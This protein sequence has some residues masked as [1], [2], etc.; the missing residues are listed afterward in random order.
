MDRH[1]PEYIAQAMHV[2]IASDRPGNATLTDNLFVETVAQRVKRLRAELDLTQSEV[3]RRAGLSQV[4]ISD[5][6]RG[7][8]KGSRE[9]LQ[10]A[11]ALHTSVEYLSTGRENSRDA[12][13]RLAES[14]AIGQDRAITR[15]EV[16]DDPMG[17]MDDGIPM[18]AAIEVSKQWMD[19]KIP[20][21]QHDSLK[22]VACQDDSMEPTFKRNDALMIDTSERRFESDGVYAFYLRDG[23][24]VKRIQRLPDGGVRVISDNRAMY[25][26][27][28]MSER[29]CARAVVVG[30]VVFVWSGKSL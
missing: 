22:I 15:I 21:A 1:G 3:G 28:T 26:P 29:E 16:I 5:I 13:R 23:A 20:T 9:L 7:R 18:L 2:N 10:L 19:G 11:N 4:T 14:I 17:R 24:F 6:E 12:P 25:D 27:Y 30:R 8:N